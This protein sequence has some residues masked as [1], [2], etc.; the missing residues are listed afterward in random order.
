MHALSYLAVELEDDIEELAGMCPVPAA[1]A[2][3]NPEWAASHE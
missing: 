2:L 3:V 1:A